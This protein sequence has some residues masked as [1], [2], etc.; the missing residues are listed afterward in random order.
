VTFVKTL[1]ASV[2]KSVFLTTGVT[3]DFTEFTKAWA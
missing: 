3:E 1:V 2:V